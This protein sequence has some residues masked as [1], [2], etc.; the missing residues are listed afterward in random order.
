MAEVECCY[1]NTECG[2]L[3][4]IFGAE[5]FRT[6]VYGRLFTTESDHKP[7]ESITQKSFADTS[8][9]LQCMLLYLQGYNYILCYHPGKESSSQIHSHISSPNLALRLH[10][11][12][13]STMPACP[14]SKRKPSNWLLRWMLRCMPW[15]T[16][17]PLAGLMISRKFHIHYIPTGNTMSHSLLKMDLCSMEKPSSF[18]HQK[19]RWSLVLYTS[20]TKASP[21]HSCLPMVAFSGLVSTRPLKKLFGNVKSA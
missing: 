12:L 6:Y 5:C 1:A 8:A 13:T 16:S 18:L 15:L 9:Q 14:L 10:W 17:T 11:I 21:K 19:G 3:A 2:I 7:L 20:H 4:F